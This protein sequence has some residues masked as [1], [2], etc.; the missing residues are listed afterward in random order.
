[1]HLA[2]T[3]ALLLRCARVCPK[4]WARFVCKFSRILYIQRKKETFAW[5]EMELQTK[6]HRGSGMP[7]RRRDRRTGC[8][9]G[10]EHP[11]VVAQAARHCS[12]PPLG[13][14]CVPYPRLCRVCT[15]RT[16]LVGWPDHRHEQAPGTHNHRVKHAAEQLLSVCRSQIVVVD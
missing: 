5:L 3:T 9:H 7:G 16:P 4:T 6:P 14:L 12:R 11:D 15:V 2:T 8:E 1:M 10:G 13:R